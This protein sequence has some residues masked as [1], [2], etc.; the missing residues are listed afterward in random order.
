MRF[1]HAVL[2]DWITLK[3][4]YSLLIPPLERHDTREKADVDRKYVWLNAAWG[5]VHGPAK[6]YM[7]LTETTSLFPD[8]MEVHDFLSENP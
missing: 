2:L 3:N 1:R 4:V 6:F 5:I 8:Q 7:E